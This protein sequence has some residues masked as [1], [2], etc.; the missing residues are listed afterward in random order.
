[1]LVLILEVRVRFSEWPSVFRISILFIVPDEPWGKVIISRIIDLLFTAA[2]VSNPGRHGCP[3]I[4]ATPAK[5]LLPTSQIASVWSWSYVFLCSTSDKFFS[6]HSWL[7]GNGCSRVVAE[8]FPTGSPS[9]QAGTGK[10]RTSVGGPGQKKPMQFD[11]RPNQTKHGIAL[12]YFPVEFIPEPGSNLI[13]EGRGL[14]TI[15]AKQR[16]NI[17][18]PTTHEIP[19]PFFKPLFGFAAESLGQKGS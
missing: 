9:S 19:T 12:C 2:P 11:S 5:S 14:K 17:R 3:K 1:M 10:D 18:W 13:G 8:I 15:Q 6:L 16:K 4:S 7:N